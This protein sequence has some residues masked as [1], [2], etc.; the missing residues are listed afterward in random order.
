MDIV[1]RTPASD[2]LRALASALSSWQQDGGPIQLH[3]GDLGWF[4]MRGP[5][6]TARALRAWFSG[7][8]LL[9]LGLLE[10]AERGRSLAALD[11]D[12]R[13]VAVAGV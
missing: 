3:P 2:E 13:V 8:K 12:G 7:G 1:L 5:D 6:A 10:L 11:P 4:S 9:G